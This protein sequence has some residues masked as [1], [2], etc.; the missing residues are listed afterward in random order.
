MGVVLLLTCSTLASGWGTT[1]DIKL[2]SNQSDFDLKF[3]ATWPLP[4]GPTVGYFDTFQGRGA[5][6]G[7]DLWLTRGELFVDGRRIDGALYLNAS[8][9]ALFAG[10][11]ALESLEANRQSENHSR[12]A[13]NFRKLWWILEGGLGLR[14]DG[15]FWYAGF[16]VPTP[17]CLTRI[18]WESDTNHGPDKY[19]RLSIVIFPFY[20]KGPVI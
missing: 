7:L 4:F 11:A 20:F 12:I 3:D 10:E 8:P 18:S 19:G 17:L 13:D 15:V 1:P 14:R 5:D 16:R 9:F 6:L 2:L